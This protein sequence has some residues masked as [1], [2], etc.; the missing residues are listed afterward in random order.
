MTYANLPPNGAPGMIVKSL[1]DHWGLF[2]G[3]GILLVVLGAAAI[4]VPPLASIAVALFLGWLFLIG[5]IAGLATTLAG[6]HAPGFWWSL[7]SAVAALIAGILLIGW[8]LRGVLSLTFVLAAFLFADGVLTILF[9]IDHRRGL[10]RRWGW[11]LVNGVI[12]LLLS[13]LIIWALPESA[14]WALG[15][16]AGIDLL[17]GGFALVAMALAARPRGTA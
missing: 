10:S 3:E 13:G 8:P 15:I 12:D 5:G 2:L 6:R 11:L 16:I 4:I 17:F 9:A 14:A 7:L 1:R